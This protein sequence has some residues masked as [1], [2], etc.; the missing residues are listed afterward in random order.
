V[1]RRGSEV[2]GAAD[3][4][5]VLARGSVELDAH[6]LALRELRLAHEADHVLF[7]TGGCAHTVDDLHAA[8]P[9][10]GHAELGGGHR[11][12]NQMRAV[13]AAHSHLQRIWTVF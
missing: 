6:P 9:A 10:H 13:F 3:A 5:V 2:P 12:N 1:A 11:L 7:A 4:A 8:A